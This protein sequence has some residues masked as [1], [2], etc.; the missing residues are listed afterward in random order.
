[1]TQQDVIAVFPLPNVVFFPGTNLPLHIFE[2]RYLEMVKDAVQ[3]KQLI[4]IFL[5]QP[6]WE[7]QY[8]GNPP[9]FPV[10]CAG[11]LL[12][13]EQAPEDRFNI[14]LRGLYRARAIETVQELPYRR[15]RVEALPDILTAEP[16]RI[17]Q[18]Q[19]QLMES[20]GKLAKSMTKIEPKSLGHLND[21]AEIVNSIA[22]ALD[23][24]VEKKMELLEENDLFLRAQS[25]G[26]VLKKQV[27][28]L[29]WTNRFAHLRPTDPNVN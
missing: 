1:M 29:E 21:F 11:E 3:N 10:G 4:G 16:D 28:L 6:G 2:P 15:M 9:V 8:Y 13:V 5:L 12:Y 18:L 23:L 24:D 7:M 19:G 14:V 26:E 17:S 20:Y 27:S 22:G 25:V